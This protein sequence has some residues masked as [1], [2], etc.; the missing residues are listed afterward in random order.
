MHVCC[1]CCCGMACHK[2]LLLLLC[3]VKCMPNHH[4]LQHAAEYRQACGSLCEEPLRC[5]C[6]H[7]ALPCRLLDCLVMWA[8]CMKPDPLCAAVTQDDTSCTAASALG[9]LLPHVGCHLLDCWARLVSVPI[10][11]KDQTNAMK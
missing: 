3:S 10:P 7:Q 2:L 9:S 4:Q 6:R 11:T 8:V 1:W 5:V